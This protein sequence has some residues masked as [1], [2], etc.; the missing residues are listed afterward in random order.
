MGYN[1]TQPS[2]YNMQT[3]SPLPF[4]D[5]YAKMTNL[6]GVTRIL[7][8]GEFE[9]QEQMH[10]QISSMLPEMR[11]A[12]KLPHSMYE[13]VSDNAMVNRIEIFNQRDRENRI[14]AFV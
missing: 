7:P 6:I 1:L 10:D 3:P 11:K 5:Q 4:D 2:L 13:G 14:Y 9:K 12:Y 8:P